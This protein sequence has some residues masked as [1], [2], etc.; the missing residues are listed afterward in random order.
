MLAKS[1][2]EM[3]GPNRIDIVH[4][5]FRGGQMAALTEYRPKTLPEYIARVETLQ[6]DAG[7]ALWFRGAGDT[8]HPLEPSLYRHPTIKAHS[9]LQSLERH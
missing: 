9:D 2:P 7:Q 4:A 3:Y 8:S 6:R 5:N 1:I